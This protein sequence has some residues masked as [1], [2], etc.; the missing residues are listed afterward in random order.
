V[1][2][3]TGAGHVRADWG[4]RW[5][6]G[7]LMLWPAGRHPVTGQQGELVFT[8]DLANTIFVV[9]VAVGG[10]LLLLT[11]LLEDVVGGVLDFLHVDF[12]LGGVTLM[13][14]LL[15]FVSMFGIGGLFGTEILDLGPGAASVV[16]AGFGLVGA[17]LVFLMFRF[18]RRAEAPPNFALADLVGQRGRVAVAISPGRTGSVLVS[19][20]GA[21]HSL[22]ATADAD[23]AAG[24][25]VLITDI[26]GSTVVVTPAVATAGEGGAPNA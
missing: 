19:Y 8:L 3:L 22:S 18:L 25:I 24:A 16:G 14:L 1:Q 17:L 4:Y 23:V 20:G 9:C 10:V 12:D 11:V 7:C 6:M 5:A 21:T 26:A 15:G 13:P 2:G